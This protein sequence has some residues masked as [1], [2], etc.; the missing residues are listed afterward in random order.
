MRA[1]IK[2]IFTTIFKIE[3]FLLVNLIMIKFVFHIAKLWVN[4]N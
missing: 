1:S 2:K 3:I 4:L